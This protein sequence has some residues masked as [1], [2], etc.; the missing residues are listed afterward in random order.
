MHG[1]AGLPSAPGGDKRKAPVRVT[2]ITLD[3]HLKGAV[4]RA[5]EVLAEDNIELTLHAAS[6][7]GSEDGSLEGAKK[8]IEEADIVIATMLFLD[9]HVRAILPSLEARREDCDAM[10]CLMSAG[11]V[12]KLT[13]MGGYRMDAPAKGPL[14]LLKKLRGSKKAGASSGAGQMKML[15]RL[16]KILKFIPG[17]A[18]DVRAYFL[19]LQYW[20]AGSDENVIAMTRALID[21]YAAGERADRRGETKADAPIDYPETGVYHPR[22]RQRISETLRLLP[23]DG[24]E[25]GKGKNGTVGLILLRSYLLGH[26]SGHYDGAIAAFEAAGMK[27]VPVFASGL[28]AR[29]AIE[30]FFVED[31]EPVVDAI[32]N[33]TGFSLVG[34]P[35]YND[36]QAA[37]EILG[38]LDVPYVAAHAIE[39]QSLEE[40]RSRDQGLLPLEATM[41]VALPELDG[42]ITPSVF[43]GRPAPGAAVCNG[44]DRKCERA[45]AERLNPMQGCP[46]RAEALANRV[47]KLIELR[48]S[49]R[50]ARKL[51]VV[52]FNFPPNAGATGTAA[53]LAVYESLHATLTRLSAEGYSVEVPES[54]DALREAILN[55][56]SEKFGSDA[57][58]AHRV[59]ADEHVRRETHLAEIEAQW[60]PAPGKA[61]T[62]G[63]HIQVLGAHFGNVFVGIQPAFGYEGDPMRMLFEGNFA[64][65]HAF[66]VFYRY[67]RE[68]FGAHSILH[69]GTHGALEFMPGKQVGMT[70]EC[71]PERLIGNVPNYYLYAANNPTE[72]MIAKR[73]GGATLV[74]Y[75]TPPLAQ[76]GLYKGLTELKAS[77]E[78]W[79]MSD[80]PA[81]RADL[82]LIIADQCDAL[83]I[84]YAD[85]SELS[86]KLYELE[87][88][89][90]PHG[91][92]VLGSNPAGERREAMLDAM[93]EAASDDADREA[94]GNMLDSSDELGSLIHA[95][96]GGYVQP[97]PGGDVVANPDVLPTG[98]N[99]HGF[100]PFLIPSAYACKQG[101]EQAERL[102]ARHVESGA[103][104]PSSIAMVLWGTDNMKSE[105]V[106]IAQAMTLIG[107][108]PRRDSYGRLCG[109]ELI[110]LEELGRP[111]I[112]VVMTLSGIFRDLLP[113]QTRMLAEA[114]LLAAQADEPV[115]ANFVRKHSLNHAEVHGVD[116]EIAA[117][118][119]FSNQEGAYGAQVNQ[120]IDGGVWADPDELANAF[121]INKGFAYGVHGEP[122]QRRELLTSALKDVEFTYQNLESIEVGITD[123]DQYVDGLG[124][125]SRSVAR[126][127]GKD[128]PVYI[129]DATRGNAKVRTLAEQID[130]E[131]RTRTLNP[132]WFEGLL[133]HG[134]EGVRN[135]EQ[136]VTNTLGW[137]ATTGE[138]APWVYQKISETFVLD[139]QMRRRLSEL[140]PKASARVAGRLLEACDRHLWEPDEATLAALREANDELEDRLEGVF[141]AEN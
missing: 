100:D 56:N 131:T 80:D 44:C 45:A 70:G 89:L 111:R 15:R 81:E 87:E 103:E 121:E 75:L 95:L 93:M 47:A 84:E 67:I 17:T 137:S 130:L 117:L 96:D 7:W 115:H 9:D 85:I 55:G 39:F 20:L 19:T 104:F 34:G 140:N 135:I 62:D 11:E 57:N 112:D 132:K 82:A 51:A 60:G 69:F 43:G 35:A 72:G 53:F 66:S 8:A 136:H 119:V 129:L 38:N 58:V 86:Q 28:D 125:V 27:V 106:Q 139:E 41:M 46:E 4:D 128:A 26:D 126:A 33:L 88:A 108:R 48:R 124:G 120:M 90:I 76:A 94:I 42:S 138:V 77:V 18:Q 118:R 110:P 73:R 109:A 5:D 37:R 101:A 13:R 98:R 32:V 14:A 3:N 65:T 24:K 133:D 107:A 92:H 21:R 122:V 50:A 114:A 64:P 61:Q 74:S 31:G 16:P 127:R 116:I 113:L 1:R 29:P 2:I 79:R 91:L 68:D 78:R 71:W 97:A 6:G 134:F 102:L 30:K 10:V 59:P 22:T 54:V 63:S 23:R 49:A 99:I 25:N 52:L 141:V 40:W 105:G 12:V 36:A 83:D 123:L